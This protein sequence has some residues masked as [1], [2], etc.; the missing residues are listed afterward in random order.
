M[1]WA[2]YAGAASEGGLVDLL[3]PARKS[4]VVGPGESYRVRNNERERTL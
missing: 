1:A 2:A 4:M 3:R